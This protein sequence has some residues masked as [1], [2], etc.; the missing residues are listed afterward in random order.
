LHALN[1]VDR[2]SNGT[3]HAVQTHHLP[4]HHVSKA[5]NPHSTL[6]NDYHVC[7][8]GGC[9][10]TITTLFFGQMRYYEPELRKGASD[11]KLDGTYFKVAVQL[12][13]LHS[14]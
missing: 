2:I 7:D 11:E 4:L 13:L 12:H 9:P 14:I 5:I 1:N 10:Q 8:T 3:W 6:I